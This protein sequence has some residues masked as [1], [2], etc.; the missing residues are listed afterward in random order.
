MRATVSAAA[1]FQNIPLDRIVIEDQ[2]RTDAGVDDED[3]RGFVDSIAAKG[4]L[5]PIIVAPFEDKFFLL[6]GERR[7]LACRKLGMETIPARVVAD[8]A[9]PED[10][11]AI[12]LT[13]NLQRQELDPL[14]KAN[15]IYSFFR[16]RHDGMDQ[17][18]VMNNLISFN[19]DP[20]R[21]E[22][23]FAATVAAISKYVGTKT[24][25]LENLLS[26]LKLPAEIGDA[27]KKGAIPVSQGYILAANL[28]NP[29]LMTVFKNILA[30][31]VTNRQLTELL[32]KAAQANT[33]TPGEAPSPF[34]SVYTAGQAL[35]NRLLDGKV[36]YDLAALEELRLYF[37]SLVQIVEKAKAG[38]GTA[39]EP[40]AP[41]I[42]KILSGPPVRGSSRERNVGRT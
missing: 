23:G 15:A 8:I 1:E 33:V 40:A 28:E 24:R 25:T 17:E 3:S 38:G 34:Q 32:K 27:V 4:V 41:A 21:V 12:Q 11:L 30:T 19:R 29:G 14:D 36:R 31:P 13:E 37:L 26:L 22:A 42:R 9:G 39:K 18:A 6:A 35:S 16:V 10:V 7:C 5:E 2:I 20:E